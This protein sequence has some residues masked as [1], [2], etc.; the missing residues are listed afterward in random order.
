MNVGFGNEVAQFHFWECWF[1]IFGIHSVTQ[2]P[3]DEE[4][5]V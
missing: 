1:R 2:G 3:F 5:K 4:Q